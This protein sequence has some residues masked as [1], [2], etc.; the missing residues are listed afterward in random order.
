MLRLW[1]CIVLAACAKTPGEATR[2]PEAP[3]VRPT[4]SK[5][6]GP[7]QTTAREL[8]DDFTRPDADG[9]ALLDKYRD[10]ARFTATIKTVGVDEGG[11]PVA[12]IDIDG[13]NVMVLDFE[14]P[15]PSELQAGAR[16]TVTCRIGGASGALMM[17][18]RCTS[19]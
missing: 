5:P 14:Q 12:W 3:A 11:V 17:V 6:R 13:E 16:L 7:V 2:D 15:A 19:S 8:F 9:L 1:L 18:T 4:A 10:G